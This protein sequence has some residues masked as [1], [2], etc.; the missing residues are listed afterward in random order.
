M[1]RRKTDLMESARVDCIVKSSRFVA[2]NTLCYELSD[3]SECIQLHDTVIVRTY[4]DGKIKLDSGG[5]KTATTKERINRYIGSRKDRV[6]YVDGMIL[7]PGKPLPHTDN[8]SNP[9]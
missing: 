1:A 8:S 3:G 9:V 4:P 5:W 2:P 6:P 7:E